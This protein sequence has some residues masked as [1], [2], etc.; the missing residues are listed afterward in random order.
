MCRLGH[1]TINP[2]NKQKGM[3]PLRVFLLELFIIQKTLSFTGGYCGFAPTIENGYI[4]M[5]TGVQ[6]GD[7]TE[8]ECKAG[9]HTNDTTVIA[10]LS[11]NTWEP[12]PRC[13]CKCFQFSVFIFIRKRMLINNFLPFP[14]KNSEF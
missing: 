8:Y 11:N 5:A 1:K 2:T 7:R 10:C 12:P 6:G 14:V 4:V 3:S 9:Y 13:S